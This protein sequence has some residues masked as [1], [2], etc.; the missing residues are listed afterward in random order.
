MFTTDLPHITKDL[1]GTEGIIRETFEDFTVEEVPVF[2]PD[3]EGEHL[4]V[5]LTKRGISTRK[6]ALDLTAQF[7][8][9]RTEV[10]F[11]GLKDVRS[12]STQTLSLHL[13]RITEDEIVDIGRIIEATVPVGVNWLRPHSRKLRAGQLLGNRFSINITGLS[14][15]P[16]EALARASKIAAVL[17]SGGLP[18]FLRPPEG[19]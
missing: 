18:K 17:E 1:P 12:V 8:L 15:D 11:A 3:G 13:G 16:E 9:G 4:F 19:R 2:E 14:L 6:L 7:G 10:G 5:N